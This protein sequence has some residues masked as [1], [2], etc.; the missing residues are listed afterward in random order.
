MVRHQKK[1]KDI[2]YE[3]YPL[4]FSHS[5]L[6]VNVDVLVSEHLLGSQQSPRS[7]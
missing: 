1:Q 2:K 7:Q 4:V 3:K 6:P 5:A